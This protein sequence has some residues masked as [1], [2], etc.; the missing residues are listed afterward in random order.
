ML[1]VSR[2]TVRRLL[3]GHRIQRDEGVPALPVKVP[4]PRPGKLDAH[5]DVI[6]E[7]LRRY[8]DITAQRVFEELRAKGYVGGYS[9]VSERLR[10]IRPAPVRISLPTPSYASGEMGECD[11]STYTLDFGG[12]RRSVQIFLLVPVVSR[13]ARKHARTWSRIGVTACSFADDSG[14]E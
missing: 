6:H 2:N 12:A 10:A 13:A 8:P 5:I 9:S 4:V 11:W 1:K 7:L 14:H 3:K